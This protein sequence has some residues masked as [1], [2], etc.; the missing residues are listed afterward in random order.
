MVKGLL[1]QVDNL[2][3][4]LEWEQCQAETWKGYASKAE[5][6][7]SDMDP[8]T[9]IG[10]VK[11]TIDALRGAISLAKEANASS[12]NGAAKDAAA[13]GL[14]TAERAAKMAEAQFAQALGLQLCQCTFPPQIMLASGRHPSN[15]QMILKC[16]RC[17]DQLPTEQYLRSIDER[18]NR[19]ADLARRSRI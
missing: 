6:S 11:L 18:K 12:P 16:P 5:R 4:G 10:A 17:Q 13:A 15:G 19:I 2:L 8:V 9:A 14:D 7:R 3:R 1:F